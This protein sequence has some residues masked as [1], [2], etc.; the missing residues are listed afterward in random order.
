MLISETLEIK[1]RR[2]S[3]PNCESFS[4]SARM[5]QVKYRLDGVAQRNGIQG[6]S[7]MSYR[8]KPID[9]SR[10]TLPREICD[11]TERLA[12]NAHDIWATQRMA[13]GWRFGSK[14]DDA[15]KEHPCLVP[16]PELP[17]SEKEYDRKAAMETLKAILAFGYRIGKS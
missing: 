13:E 10:I 4:P 3:I 11:L 2:K 15:R 9:T 6:A 14:R 8:P 12:E 7:G 1:N 17:E 5:S 16:Y